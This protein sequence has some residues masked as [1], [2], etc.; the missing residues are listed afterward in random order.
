[1]LVLREES[2]IVY[3]DIA[4]IINAPSPSHLPLHRALWGTFCHKTSCQTFDPLTDKKS[5]LKKA[6]HKLFGQVTDI[7]S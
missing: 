5:S 3:L 4:E 2:F 6:C 1:M 7:I